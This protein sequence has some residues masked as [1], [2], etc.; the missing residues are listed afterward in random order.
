M[1]LLNKRYTYEREIEMLSYEGK[2]EVVCHGY[3]P[4][5]AVEVTFE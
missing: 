3:F 4:S 1:A 5:A 2:N